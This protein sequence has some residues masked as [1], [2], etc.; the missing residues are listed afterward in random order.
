M[1]KKEYEERLSY[2]QNQINELKNEINELKNV[3]IEDGEFPQYEDKYWY[4]SGRGEVEGD[5]WHNY[6]ADNYR[7]DFLRIFKTKE[8]CKRYLEIQKAFKKASFKP[9]WKDFNQEKYYFYYNYCD[10]EIA[11]GIWYSLRYSN[12]DY[13]ESEKVIEDLFKRFGEEDVK[14]YYLGIEE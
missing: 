2:L 8:E 9:D 13:F 10:K 1:T 5:Y 14:K 6:C 7:K 12:A 11:I 3:E 4:V